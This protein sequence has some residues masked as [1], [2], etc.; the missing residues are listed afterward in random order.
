[1]DERERLSRVVARRK[2][3]GPAARKRYEDRSRQRLAAEARRKATT[4]F[5]GALAEFEKFFGALWGHGKADADRT[6]REK[7][8]FELWQRC[9]NEVLNRGNAQVRALEAEL[10]QY[11][12]SWS[13]HT[14]TLPA[15]REDGE[16]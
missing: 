4:G 14:L 9:R 6:E 3:E 1:V 10:A 16:L 12:V 2:A 7:K 8:W 11:V 13:R 15:L 5:I